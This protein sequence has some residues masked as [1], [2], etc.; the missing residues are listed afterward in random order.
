[1]NKTE[2]IIFYL[3]IIT[4]SSLFA[5]ISQIK[6]NNHNLINIRT[7]S[8]R[9]NYNLLMIIISYFILTLPLAFRYNTGADYMSYVNI[10]KNV[11][12]FGIQAVKMTNTELGYVFLNYLCVKI[13]NDYQSI[14]MVTAIITNYFFYKA[15]TYESKN[16]NLGLAIFTYGFASY[17][18]EY[19]ILRNMLGISIAFYAL[20]F[21]FEKKPVKYFIFI[22]IA[23][24]FHNSLIIFYILGILYV[25]NFKKYRLKIA[26]IAIIMIPLISK[27]IAFIS[28]YAFRI[29]PNYTTYTDTINASV[30]KYGKSLL[31]YLLPIIPFSLFYNKMKEINS[32]ISLYFSFYLVGAAILIL[33]YSNPLLIRFTYALFISQ[34]ILFPTI[35]RVLSK[36]EEKYKRVTI[37][38]ISLNILFVYGTILILNTINTDLYYLLPYKSFLQR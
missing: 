10:Y 12:M 37:C 20:R 11:E 8:Q 9:K 27:I 34:I 7:D 18:F 14:F 38:F 5:Y 36:I 30:N 19:G 16:I 26:L 3:L 31:V 2:S 24:L 29:S 25:E 35:F 23:V 22:T 17:F 15:I 6:K 33:S 28:V 21:I 1:M 32:N 13:F 4:T